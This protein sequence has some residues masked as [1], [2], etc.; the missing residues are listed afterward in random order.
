MKK[1]RKLI[2]TV[3]VV[4]IKGEMNFNLLFSWMKLK[5]VKSQLKKKY[6]K[7]RDPSE[8]KKRIKN[9]MKFKVNKVGESE[10]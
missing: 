7:K 4:P 9:G 5:W 2:P 8:K 6:I 1:G 3:Q 10:R